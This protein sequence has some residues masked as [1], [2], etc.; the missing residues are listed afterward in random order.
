MT[1]YVNTICNSNNI[2]VT[3]MD[4]DGVERT[5]LD[6]VTDK[7]DKSEGKSAIQCKKCQEYSVFFNEIQSRSADEGASVYYYCA[8]CLD[9]WVS[10]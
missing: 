1:K 6:A 4:V 5:I 7:F 3:K 9:K 8:N 10:K 2:C